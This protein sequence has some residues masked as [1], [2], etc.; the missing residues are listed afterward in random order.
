[1]GPFPIFISFL[2][3]FRS[4]SLCFPPFVIRWFLFLAWAEMAS[5]G[6]GG[7]GGGGGQGQRCG[8]AASQK[9]AGIWPGQG[10]GD[11]QWTHQLH[12][13][14]SFAS[15]CW[16]STMS[17]QPLVAVIASPL[18]LLWCELALLAAYPTV[19]TLKQVSY[20][21]YQSNFPLLL[22]FQITPSP[23]PA[24]THPIP[25]QRPPNFNSPSLIVFTH[26]HTHTPTLGRISNYYYPQLH[27]LVRSLSLIHPLL[28]PQPSLNPPYLYSGDHHQ[29]SPLSTRSLPRTTTSVVC[30]GQPRTALLM[31]SQFQNLKNF[32]R[33]GKQARQQD[34]HTTLPKAHVL[35]D[36][37]VG[38][39]GGSGGGVSLD[40]HS[41]KHDF[42]AAVVDNRNTAAQANAVAANAAGA[43]QNMADVAYAHTTKQGGSKVY[44]RETLAKIIAEEKA[45]REKLPWY[46]GL[47][48][49]I[50]TQKM[51]DGA[52][53]NV[54]RARDTQEEYG[55]VA[56]K[57]V[58]KYELNASQVCSAAALFFLSACVYFCLSIASGET[59]KLGA[60]LTFDGLGLR[61]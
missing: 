28:L 17:S 52:F 56:I 38:N 20:C 16:S 51:G 37:S 55:E 40:G 42:S 21:F 12:T 18:L 6:E 54:Y 35:S 29:H 1:V 31:A 43:H 5:G 27:L 59:A 48:R 11:K 61:C 13:C 44:D 23:L 2:F 58:R 57:V 50:L 32:I 53:S 19:P 25:P 30:V 41:Q 49:W 33:H 39:H 10:G 8:G 22:S 3:F 36:P 24:Y 45:N 34:P 60:L 15:L 7:E 47:D 46:P 26:T 4:L 14:S 9:Q